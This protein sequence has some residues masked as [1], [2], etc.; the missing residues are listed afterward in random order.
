VQV[1]AVSEGAR[2]AVEAA[3]GKVETPAA[4]PAPGKLKKKDRTQETKA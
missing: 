1:D 4:K 2:K 3:G